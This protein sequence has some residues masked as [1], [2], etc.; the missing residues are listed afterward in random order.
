[1]LKYRI[2]QK[3]R[4]PD[5]ILEIEGIEGEWYVFGVYGTYRAAMHDVRFLQQEA[6]R[7]EGMYAEI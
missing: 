1:M 6:E 3:G 5:F 4:C 7:R 2:C